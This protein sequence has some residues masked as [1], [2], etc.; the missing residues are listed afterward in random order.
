MVGSD[1]ELPD[2]STQHVLSLIAS[3]D[4][5]IISKDLDGII[6]TWNAGA[7]RIFGYAAEEAIGQSIRIVIPEDLQAEEDAILERL[8]RGERIEHYQT[9]RR[10]KSGRDIHVSL[11]IS[12]IRDRAGAIIGASKI[13]RD[14]SRQKL[15]EQELEQQRLRLE[16]LNHIARVL[17]RD[18]DLDRIVQTVTDIATEL[19]GARYG[20]FFYN[21]TGETGET[22]QLYTLSGVPRSAFGSFPMPRNTPIFDATFK[23]A[24]TVRSDDIR[25]DPRYGTLEPHYGQPT[26]HLTVVSY[27]AVPVISRSGDVLGGLL[28]GHDQPGMFDQN[29]EAMAIGIA[30]HAAVAIDNARLHR[31][32][33]L[34]LEQRKK[35][36]EAREFLLREMQHRVKNTFGTVLAIAGQTF[37]GASPAQHQSFF[38]RV[39]ALSEAH[40]LLTHV[41][42]SSVALRDV[43]ANA[44]EPFQSADYPRV[45]V[46]GPEVELDP[47]KALTLAMVLHELCTNA[48]KYGALSLDPGIISISW[49]TGKRGDHRA[50]KITWQE[51][52][53]PL[54]PPPTHRGFGSTLIERALSGTQGKASLH[55]DRHGLICIIDMLL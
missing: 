33:Q 27:L 37:K 40:A 29:A 14:I 47:G 30:A 12:P 22:Y 23:G 32:A 24:A 10:N 11:T 16:R 49:E 43:I 13:A 9:L 18:L 38:A 15:A 48:V 51:D 8:C 25:K 21:V 19:T 6:R 50:V 46:S 2:G 36:E 39:R 26:G 34:E 20:A 4:D 31:A 45:I 1:D 5:A 41:S 55:Y 52:G 53:G 28:F 3:S 7:T 44:I 17:A 42:W 54:V 35:A